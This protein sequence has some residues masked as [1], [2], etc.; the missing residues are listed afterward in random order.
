[1]SVAVNEAA[2][3]SAARFAKA[4]A[5]L[6]PHDGLTSARLA[7]AVSG[8]PDSMALAFCVARWRAETPGPAPIALIVDHG[9]RP[10]SAQEA[11]DTAGRLSALG[12]DSRILRWNHASLSPRMHETARRAR[13]KLLEEACLSLDCTELLLAHHADDQAET[14]LMRLAKGSGPAG[15]AGISAQSRYNDLRLLRPFLAVPGIGKAELIAT[16][17]AAGIAFAADPSNLSD[18]YARGRLR[19]L[20]PLLAAEG[21]SREA[22]LLVGQR[23]A[24]AE[25]AL[26]ATVAAFL[27]NH[28]RLIPGGAVRIDLSPLRAAPRGLSLRVLAAAMDFIHHG[29][30]PPP[31]AAMS[32]LCAAVLAEGAEGARSL[33]GCLVSTAPTA[34]TILREPSSI[35]ASVPFAPG[36]SRLWDERWLVAA[37]PDFALPDGCVLAPLTAAG[38]AA[39]K[40]H[41]PYLTHKVPQGRIRAA[42]PGLWRNQELIAIPDFCDPGGKSDAPLTATLA[43]HFPFG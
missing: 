20:Q 24:E 6:S 21:F 34:L 19:R 38:R 8:G 26:A 41:S 36:Q 23:A 22:L 17:A 30:H 15:L 43:K 31:Y 1:M 4:L 27:K 7:I 35:R 18:K 32:D 11:A 28:A 13:Y 10:E 37:R 12:I 40:R 2:P 33:A 5:R 3:V 16:C 9:L 39:V 25:E 42:L 14:I 29:D